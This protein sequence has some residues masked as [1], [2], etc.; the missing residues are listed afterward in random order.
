MEEFG[1]LT[2]ITV[3]ITRKLFSIVVHDLENPDKKISLSQWLGVLSVFIGLGLEVV[4]NYSKGQKIQK[5]SISSSKS[6]SK[7]PAKATTEP[8]S[9][10][11][12]PSKS[13]TPAKSPAK[14]SAKSKSPARQKSPSRSKSPARK[15]KSKTD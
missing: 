7:S 15:S 4:M 13:K 11:R 3:S 10:G 1:S 14:S 9:R 8:K 6:S 12:P 2:W 5:G